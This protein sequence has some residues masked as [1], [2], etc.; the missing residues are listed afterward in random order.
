MGVVKGARDVLITHSAGSLH[1]RLPVDLHGEGFTGSVRGENM[2][3]VNFV[4]ILIRKCST[5][6]IALKTG[7]KTL[8][9][10]VVFSG[11]NKHNTWKQRNYNG[12]LLVPLGVQGI[13]KKR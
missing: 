7:L 1:P 2:K 8:I 5:Q 4:N 13:C 10:K 9:P 12:N 6:R 3:Q 11:N